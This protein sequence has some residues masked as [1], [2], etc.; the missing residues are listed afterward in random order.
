M[1]E[2]KMAGLGFD[3]VHTAVSYWLGALSEPVLMISREDMIRA[4]GRGALIWD[5]RS[6]DAFERE[7]ASGALNLG[8][9][10][11][12]LAD[13]CGGNLIPA[14]VIEDTL[15][16]AGIQKAR[17]VVIYAEQPAVDAFVALRALRSIG[18]CDAQVCLGDAAPAGQRSAQTGGATGHASTAGVEHP[19]HA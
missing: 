13:N 16:Q 12:L 7:H 5:V 19:L 6:H 8:G 11:W 1:E 2:T 3:M 18:I 14:S 4:A 10:D 15:V 9:V 17:P